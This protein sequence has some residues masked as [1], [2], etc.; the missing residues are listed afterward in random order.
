MSTETPHPWRDLWRLSWPVA[1]SMLATISMGL[2]DMMMLGRIGAEALASL[3]LSITWW[4]TV[5]VFSRNIC[6]GLEPFVSQAFGAGRHD[7]VR[8]WLAQGLFATYL[9]IPPYFVLMIFASTGLRWL[10]QPEELMDN[11]ELYCRILALAIPAEVTFYTLRQWLQNQHHVRE[12]LVAIVIA[13]GLNIL[14]NWLLIF[15][16]DYG[17]AGCA[18]ATLLCQCLQLIILAGLTWR[19][20]LAVIWQGS[21]R[22]VGSQILL[23]MR[24][25][26]PSAALIAVESWGFVAASIMVG[27]I[28]S[29]ALAAHSIGLNIVSTSFMVVLGLSTAASTLVGNAVGAKRAWMPMVW[30]SV[31]L[32]SAIQIPVAI[33]LWS[34]PAF[35]ASI[36]T[37]DPAVIEL[38]VI[39]LRVGALFQFCDGV[40]VLLFAL[41]RALGDVKW[42]FWAGLIAHWCIGLPLAYWLG[43]AQGGGIGGVWQGLLAALVCASILVSFRIWWLSQKPIA[44]LSEGLQHSSSAH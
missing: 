6:R 24:Y 26:I 5:G 11:V 38:A 34:F 23:L 31:G 44:E 3:S 43:E 29:T 4:V 41:L 27:W 20:H 1:L 10:G 37:D 35:F 12:A 18:V 32:M 13:N 7:A 36:F 14:F 16:L 19:S 25:A 17:I 42:P 33:L 30:R 28:G 2:V 8:N 15:Q 22:P 9:W 21:L 39:V 40:Q